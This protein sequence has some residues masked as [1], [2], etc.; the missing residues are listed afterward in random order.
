[1]SRT[2]FSARP[3][4]VVLALAATTAMTAAVVTYAGAAPAPERA[5][6][7]AATTLNWIGVKKVDTEPRSARAGA[8][9]TTFLELREDSRGRPGKVIGD[10][11][12][13]CGTVRVTSNGST[14][15]CQRVLRT[16]KGF[17]ALSAMIDR[18]G[19]GPY[20]G[21]SVVVGGTGSYAGAQG[22]AE[23]VLDGKQVRFR[24]HLGG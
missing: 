23:I 17:I 1:M 18:F 19:R 20:K 9:W 21:A 2:S 13:R 7:K 5:S 3:S 10:G 6:A 11:S 24:I 12:A 15:Q 16:S 4:R 22:E 8:S 14:T